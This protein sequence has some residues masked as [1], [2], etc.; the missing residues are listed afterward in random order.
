[1]PEITY[2]GPAREQDYEELMAM[3]DDV[4]FLEDELPRRDFLTLL[5][6]LYKKE[7]RPWENNYILKEDGVIRAAVGMYVYDVQ[8]AGQMA[9]LGGIGNVAVARDSR[10]SGYMRRT[11][12]AAMEA[13]AAAGC[14]FG[15]LGGQRQRYNYWGFE[16]GGWALRGHFNR[17]NLRHMP[18]GKTELK[19]EPLTDPADLQVIQAAHERD[20]MHT[21][22]DAAAFLDALHSWDN[23]PYI[24][25]DGKGIAAYFSLD[26]MSEEI[27]NLRL[28]QPERFEEI[29]RALF[30]LLSSHSYGIAVEAAA[31][32]HEMIACF[33]KYSESYHPIHSG[34]YAV[35]RWANGL[36]LLMQAQTQLKPLEE[37][38]LVARIHG[39][40]GDE[41]V[42]IAV[43]Q[44]QPCVTA[45]TDV[46]VI[47]LEH[48]DAVR[49]FLTP[50][51]SKR[52]EWAVRYPFLNN[53]LPL[54]LYWRNYDHV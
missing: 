54:P 50:Y 43:E 9:R 46:P 5:P 20:L 10:R 41:T 44:G 6:K 12:D 48:L 30:S 17:S 51:S 42:R 8:I 3:L 19:A 38:S 45:T 1:M 31:W 24:L 16:R 25:R 34:S 7:Y 18:E 23:K 26:R 15:F 53:W 35:L 21:K 11:M 33:E 4:F 37:G 13:M 47:E 32:D 40:C 28:L 49:F 52:E 2:I 27:G 39:Q 22:H 36:S 14:S 29:L